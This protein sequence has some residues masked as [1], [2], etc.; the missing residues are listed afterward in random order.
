MARDGMGRVVC[1]RMDGTLWRVGEP[2]RSSVRALVSMP[3]L[4]ALSV[5]EGWAALDDDGR[6]LWS[7]D[8]AVAPLWSSDEDIVAVAGCAVGVVVL[9]RA[10]DKFRVHWVDR[11]GELRWSRAL[12]VR[13][14]DASG[15]APRVEAS[16]H[17][18]GR[19]LMIGVVVCGR[20]CAFRVHLR[21]QLAELVLSGSNDDGEVSFVF[22]RDGV[23]VST[24]QRVGVYP[25]SGRQPAPLWT[26]ALRREPL[27]R[28]AAIPATVQGDVVAF[29]AQRV[30]VCTLGTGEELSSLNG[31]WE[32]VSRLALDRRLGLSV[33]TVPSSS[34]LEIHYA[35]PIALLG[36]VSGS[37]SGGRADQT[38]R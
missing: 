4:R 8:R 7:G 5:D 29:G 20:W 34:R 31:P 11:V 13:G 21:S 24:S 37:A 14:A 9:A 6:R 26:R 15:D 23:L 1:H 12:D 36:L 32:C 10:G 18:S 35:A 33:V 38:P 2:L 16:L 3:A 30:S 22:A 28:G 27:L 25:D 17:A 19:S